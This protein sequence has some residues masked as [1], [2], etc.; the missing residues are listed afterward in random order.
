[1]VVAVFIEKKSKLLQQTLYQVDKLFTTRIMSSK[2]IIIVFGA[3][4]NQ[5]GS[6][7]DSLLNDPDA[8]G[9]FEIHGV[10][11]D[12]AKPAALALSERGVKVVEVRTIRINVDSLVNTLSQASLEDIESLRL[13]VKGAY[14][15]FAVTNWNEIMDKEREIQQGKNIADVSKV[16]IIDT[17][18]FN[19]LLNF[20]GM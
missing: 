5:G 6:V 16:K 4:G 1:V 7:I 17:T 18:R 13:I 19:K 10:T 11:R 12:S 8:A 15:V 14:A 9:K 20:L 2:K 3:L